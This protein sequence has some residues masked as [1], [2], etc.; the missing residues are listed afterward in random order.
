MASSQ[1]SEPEQAQ[2]EVEADGRR[3]REAAGERAEPR[4][5]PL[6]RLLAVAADR[7]GRLGLGVARRQPGRLGEGALG[8]ARA[9]EPLERDAVEQLR[10]GVGPG[11]RC[12]AGARAAAGGSSRR[13]PQAARSPARSWAGPAPGP[14]WSRS[15]ARTAKTVSGSTREAARHSAAASASRPAQKYASPRC[16]RTAALRGWPA[17]SCSSRPCVPRGQRTSARPMRAWSERWRSKIRAASSSCPCAYSSPARRRS[18]ASGSVRTPRSRTSGGTPSLPRPSA[19]SRVRSPAPIATAAATR[20]AT[21]T[22]S[23]MRT[24][25]DTRPDRYP[26]WLSSLS[27]RRSEHEL[28]L[29]APA[30]RELLES[31]EGA[32]LVDVRGE[33]EWAGRLHPRRRARAAARP[34]RA[35]RRG[36]ARPLAATSSSTARSARAR[37]ARRTRCSELGYERPVSIAGGIVDWMA[38][39]YPSTS[40]GRS[41]PT[42]ASATAVTS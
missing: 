39:G 5:R 41:S 38:R 4:E 16:R 3:P 29:D 18:R 11:S 26:R 21:A 30:A 31:D 37:C 7:G 14:G 6:G 22:T 1:V 35:D 33:D 9:S 32:V 10:A 2:P 8:R 15:E 23:A 19:S 17:E 25:G 42:S 24:R 40:S 28:E 20:A 36:R 12:G 34:G 13:A 27:W